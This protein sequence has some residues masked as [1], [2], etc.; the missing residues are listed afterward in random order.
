[1][2]RSG[3]KP[4]KKNNIPDILLTSS[5]PPDNTS[6]TA[7]ESFRYASHYDTATY[8]KILL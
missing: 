4:M 3:S 6:D 7:P 1:M 5:P 2:T 8:S